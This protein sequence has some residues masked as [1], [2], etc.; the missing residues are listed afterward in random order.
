VVPAE[1]EVAK[2]AVR[3]SHGEGPRP[4]FSQQPF[5]PG[6]RLGGR[7]GSPWPQAAR[8]PPGDRSPGHWPGCVLRRQVVRTAWARWR[9]RSGR[10]PQRTSDG[11]T[12]E[13]RQLAALVGADGDQVHPQCGADQKVVGRTVRELG[14]DP[15]LRE[16]LADAR[17]PACAGR[18]TTT[19]QRA[20]LLTATPTEPRSRLRTVPRPRN[21]STTMLAPGRAGAAV[22]GGRDVQHVGDLQVWRSYGHVPPLRPGCGSGRPGEGAHRFVVHTRTGWKSSERQGV[23][24]LQG[25]I[26][27]P[28]R[29]RRGHDPI[30][31][32]AHAHRK[33]P[34]R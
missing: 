2:N 12:G 21:P 9:P 30:R 25:W 1:A 27:P 10:A 18:R 20:C 13:A 11:A 17:H 26:L 8:R 4:G 32:P 29:S 6:P 16:L 15:H 23:S 24:R 3:R 14:P 7:P 33:R 34:V 19:G 28:G 22:A 5:G 31:G